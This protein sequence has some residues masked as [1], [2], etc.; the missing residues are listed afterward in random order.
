MQDIKT[1]NN[2]AKTNPLKKEEEVSSSILILLTSTSFFDKNENKLHADDFVTDIRKPQSFFILLK[3]YFHEILIR[4]SR[5]MGK[6][7]VKIL[8]QYTLQ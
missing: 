8:C 4:K 6:K 3:Q 7:L 5:Q 1:D 2:T